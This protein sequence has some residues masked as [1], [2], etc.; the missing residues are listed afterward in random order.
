M[1]GKRKLIDT[2]MSTVVV[3]TNIDDQED[4]FV[5]KMVL[6]SGEWSQST[7]WQCERET[8]WKFKTNYLYSIVSI[9]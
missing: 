9:Q 3:D 5:Q 8:L 6:G 1:F 4:S 7:A 2:R